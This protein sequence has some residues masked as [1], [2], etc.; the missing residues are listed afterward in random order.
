M[1]D[2][3][4]RVLA[5]TELGE[6]PV[7]SFA[8]TDPRIEFVSGD[9]VAPAGAGPLVL[10][11]AGTVLDPEALAWLT[12]ALI[13]TGAG[14]VYADHDHGV[15]DPGLRM[16]RADPVLFGTYDE[17]LISEGIVPAVVALAAPVVDMGYGG[18]ELRKRALL[19]VARGG[20]VAHVPRLLA[21]QVSLPLIARTGRAEPEDARPGRLSPEVHSPAIRPTPTP[22]SDR[23]A[24]VIPTRD[25]A[26]LL[27]RAIDTLRATA[28]QPDRL[29][30]VVVDNR[31]VKADTAALFDRLAA[32]GAARVLRF[33]SP[34]NWSLASN[35]G[36]AASDAPLI[37]FI[38]NDVEMLSAGWDDL[39]ADGLS[40]PDAGAVGARLL[41]PDRTIQHAGIA[42]GFG[43]GG[44]EHEG[45]GV[46]AADP[47]PGRRYVVT[48]AVCALT[49]AFLAV[50]RSD[51]N[52]LGGFDA[53]RLMV[54]HSDVDL[55]LRLRELGRVIL[56]CP[57]IE[58]IHH[59]GATRGRN[60]TQAAIAWD[61]GER[62][63]LLD[64]WGEALADDPGI[65]P[66]WRRDD[67]PFELLR[68]PTI[69]EILK[70]I[71]RSAS[72]HPWQV[73]RSAPT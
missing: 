63:D 68:E 34:F 14:A 73:H 43:P 17:A 11:D 67:K 30:I 5:S 69:R 22:R 6:G 35:M 49:G 8:E 40:R 25:N 18:A 70:Q 32:D 23:I 27:G 1:S 65:S 72:R 24:V 53:A 59:E 26:G 20:R 61:E 28:R 10:L 31:S 66:Y 44:T 48:H 42:F 21:T 55:C 57:A 51:F 19:D 60:Q 58:A 36:A 4:A 29:D 71:D 15:A 13:R 12:F 38:N 7:A 33:D 45:R 41:Y 16:L 37:V 39:V 56:Y 3:S 52:Q 47:G 9:A 64:R 46:P 62:L 54:A 2:W 50:R